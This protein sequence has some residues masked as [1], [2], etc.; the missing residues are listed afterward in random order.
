M[1]KPRAFIH[2]DSQ[3][4]V[5]HVIS[6]IVDRRMVLGEAEKEAFVGM[7][8]AFEA[9]H[10]NRNNKKQQATPIIEEVLNDNVENYFDDEINSA[11]QEV[12]YLKSILNRLDGI[13]ACY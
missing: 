4:G 2:P 9:L 10:Q 6:R 5:F 3:S 7:M 1:A 11:K 8:R 13:C 12:N